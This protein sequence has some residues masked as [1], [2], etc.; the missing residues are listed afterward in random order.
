MNNSKLK[1]K[2]MLMCDKV[3]TENNTGKNSLIGVFENISAKQFPAVHPELYVYVNFT[4]ALGTYNFR[5]ELINIENGESVFPGTEI[6]NVISND[7]TMYCNLVFLLSMLNFEQSGKYE[8]RL[9][10]NGE[11]CETKAINLKQI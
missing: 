5:L 8:F 11:I 2:A 7:I 10:V 6:P 1:V 4:E 9:F 3:I